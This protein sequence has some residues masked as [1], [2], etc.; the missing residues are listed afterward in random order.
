MNTP[1]NQ[2]ASIEATQRLNQIVMEAY[3]RRSRQ[4]PANL[5]EIVATLKADIIKYM[6]T[7]GIET[8]DEAVTFET[9]HDDKTPLSPAFLFAAVRK[10]YQ[11]PYQPR[12]MDEEQYRRHETEWDTVSLLDTLA[13]NIAKG[14]KVYFNPWREYD[15]LRMRGQLSDELPFQA[16]KNAINVE[17]VRDF[18]RPLQDWTDADLDDLNARARHIAVTEW[19]KAC[20]ASGLKPSAILQPLMNENQYQQLRRTV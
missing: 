13:D 7:V 20:N 17:R 15:Y 16:A 5:T 4:L 11:P 9:L 2:I 14:S 12:K 8:V 18:M 6:P 19:L 3:K 1:L 10:H